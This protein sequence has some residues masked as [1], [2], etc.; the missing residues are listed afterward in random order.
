MY[1]TIFSVEERDS[2]Q[3]NEM[4]NP[5]FPI[6]NHE[7]LRTTPFILFGAGN[8]GLAAVKALS[9]LGIRPDWIIDSNPEK[10]GGNID[11]IPIRSPE[12][13]KEVTSQVVIIT[14]AHIHPIWEICHNAGV[15]KW[16]IFTDL[17][18][19]YGSLD[20]RFSLR[21]L[22]QNEQIVKAFSLFSHCTSSARVFK[23]SLRCRIT[24]HPHDFPAYTPDQYFPSN[25]VPLEFYRRFVDCGAFTGDTLDT[26][27]HY[28]KAIAEPKTYWGFEPNPSNFAALQNTANTF[29]P[30]HT[31]SFSLIPKAVGSHQDRA[32]ISQSGS[33]SHISDDSTKEN[34]IIIST[35]DQEIG[36][37]PVSAIKMDLEG[38]EQLALQG[39]VQT[40]IKNR[41]ALLISVYHR[42]HDF[43]EIPNW[44]DNLGLKY[45]FFLRHHCPKSFG[46]T[47]CYA[48]P[49]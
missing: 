31:I 42:T 6:A 30:N 39:A 2:I 25:V 23:D 10:W 48:I 35:I 47:V 14:S 7:I 16:T 5:T 41:P 27:I 43:W 4:P 19:V 46:E 33:A 1:P 8:L 20:Y 32:Y 36:N 37:N 12:S 15:K 9:A 24:K 26:W 45:R 40:I 11:T 22:D 28:T 17:Q 29:T 38:Y 44:I 21:E 3:R 34:S 18:V 49:Q 13:T